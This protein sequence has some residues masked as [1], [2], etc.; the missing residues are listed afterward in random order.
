MPAN[1]SRPALVGRTYGACPMRYN[2]CLRDRPSRQRAGGGNLTLAEYLD[3]TA[4]GLSQRLSQ[5]LREADDRIA[6]VQNRN[7]RTQARSW[8]DA[9]SQTAASSINSPYLAA[10]DP[11]LQ[12]Q[13]C[14]PVEL[15]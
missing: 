4:P 13:F 7:A 15:G 1:S 8:G 6:N 14:S 2:A 11:W 10:K 3:Q 9:D 5:R 12:H